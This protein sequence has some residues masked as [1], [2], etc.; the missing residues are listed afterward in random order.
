MKALTVAACIIAAELAPASVA[1][2]VDAWPSHATGGTQVIEGC[3]WVQGK[4]AWIYSD[5]SL[6]RGTGEDPKVDSLGLPACADG[7]LAVIMPETGR[8]MCKIP[9]PELQRVS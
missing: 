3:H 7:R 6:C 4:D 9:T 5:G 1:T 8:V 2:V